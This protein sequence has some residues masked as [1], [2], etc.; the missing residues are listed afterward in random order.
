M[1]VPGPVKTGGFAVKEQSA[2]RAA[3][4]GENM[5]TI[6]YKILKKIFGRAFFIVLS[7]LLQISWF[8]LFMMLLGVRYPIFAGVV[9]VCSIIVVFAIVSRQINPSYKLAWS[10][11][12]LAVPTAGMAI[13]LM[14]GR[15]RM[16]KAVRDS[17]AAAEKR[18][19]PLMSENPV[20]RDN[21]ER[22]N[23]HA[24]R[25]SQYLRDYAGYPVWQGTAAEYYSDGE[26][27]YRQ[28]VQELEKARHFI[29]LEFFI[30]DDG[31]VWETILNILE[32]K[33]KEGLDVRLVYDDVGCVNTLPAKFYKEIRKRGIQ[34]EVFNP[35]R[36]I[37]SV[38]LNNR[39]HRKIMVIDG[40]VG[41][42]GGINLADEYINR[43][44]RYGYWKDTGVMLRGEAVWNFTVMFLEMWS[45]LKND[46][47]ELESVDH[48]RPV[49]EEKAG[50]VTD[51]FIQP[52]SDTPLDNETV[53]ESVYLNMI[54]QAKHYVYIFTPYLIVDNEMI[55]A[56]CL[57]AKSGVDVRIVTPG[58]PDKKMIFL[59]SRS[60]YNQLLHAGVRIY[61]YRPG[62]LHAKC[63]VCDDELATVG[64]INLDYRSLYLHFECGVWM[65]RSRAV[66]QVK[67]DMLATI[68]VAREVTAQECEQRSALTRL[69]MNFL[70]LMAPML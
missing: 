45:V 51:G 5:M 55:T 58:I 14:F 6:L 49:P 60:Y 19:R 25:Q 69:E 62:F 17:F 10:L 53:G 40:S 41:F 37:V 46:H 61:E 8:V 68:A 24:N 34:C 57:A 20:Y 30:I 48:L 66:W 47:S 31:E 23:A 28:M 50:F 2:D 52:Y 59:L 22:A 67:E 12:I 44:T 29:F 33:A 18:C 70:R 43:K 65:Y 9:R 35:F 4:A 26:G 54:S 7:V 27:L 63:F 11:L 3:V 42:T 32:R 56:L 36:P 13:Y 15:S 39:D 1:K 38:V 64:T 21:L 16:A